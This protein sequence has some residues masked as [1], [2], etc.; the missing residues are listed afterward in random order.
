MS[1]YIAAF[2]EFKNEEEYN[3]EYRDKTIP[4]IKRH[5]GRPM[6]DTDGMIPKEGTLP[7]GRM[8]MLRFATMDAAE[9]FYSDPEYQKL[10]EVRQGIATTHLSFLP[11]ISHRG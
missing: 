1:V 3:R 5:G 7:G 9:A 10:I 6:I 2:V 4:I 8:V 11:G